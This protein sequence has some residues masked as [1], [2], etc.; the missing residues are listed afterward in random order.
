[1]SHF[2]VIRRKMLL[3]VLVSTFLTLLLLNRCLFSNSAED[4]GWRRTNQGWAH[5]SSWEAHK[6]EYDPPLTAEALHPLVV[7]S[8]EVCLAIGGLLAFESR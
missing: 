1:M 3:G 5:V 8:F 7:A 4:A 2:L 6:P